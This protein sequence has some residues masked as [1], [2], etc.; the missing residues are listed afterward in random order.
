MSEHRVTIP[1]TLYGVD[2]GNEAAVLEQ[3]R[4]LIGEAL[5]SDHFS[6]SWSIIDLGDAAADVGDPMTPDDTS[7]CPDCEELRSKVG[8]LEAWVRE[9]LAEE[10]ERVQDARRDSEPDLEWEH[11]Q[12][13]AQGQRWLDKMQSLGLTGL[14]EGG[15]K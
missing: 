6:E 15:G 2:S 5:G 3:V 11:E 12:R 8:E 14:G 4:W 13:V 10:E 7:P 1:V 9:R